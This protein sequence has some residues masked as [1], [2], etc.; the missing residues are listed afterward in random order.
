MGLPASGRRSREQGRIH[1]PTLPGRCVNDLYCTVATTGE[2][3]RVP[4]EGRFVCPHCSKTLVPPNT[5]LRRR[6]RGRRHGRGVDA[7]GLLMG[8]VGLAGGVLLGAL[9][10]GD[11]PGRVTVLSHQVVGIVPTASAAT[12]AQPDPIYV[13]VA[14]GQSMNGSRHR[15]HAEASSVA[16][17]LLR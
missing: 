16:T 17:A 10:F 7:P 5:P 3:V 14:Y 11:A 6:A 1:M 9:F 4:A 8:L 2:I 12:L 13:R 15:H